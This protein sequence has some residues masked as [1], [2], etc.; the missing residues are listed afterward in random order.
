MRRGPRA[1]CDLLFYTYI[2]V[3]MYNFKKY[4]HSIPTFVVDFDMSYRFIAVCMAV[5]IGIC[6][7]AGMVVERLWS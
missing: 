6:A 2:H 5:W 4:S 3:C 1:R 7:T